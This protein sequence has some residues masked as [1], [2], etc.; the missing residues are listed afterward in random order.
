[1]WNPTTSYSAMR[2]SGWLDDNF[3]EIMDSLTYKDDDHDSN[4]LFVPSGNLTVCYW[5]WPFIVDLPIDGM[6]MFHSSVSLPEGIIM[7]W[8]GFIWWS[9]WLNWEVNTCSTR[10]IFSHIPRRWSLQKM[11]ADVGRV[12]VAWC[13]TREIWAFSRSSTPTR[14]FC[15]PPQVWHDLVVDL[16]LWKIMDWVSNSWAYDIPKNMESQSKFH[17]SKPP[18]SDGFRELRWWFWRTGDN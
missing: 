16:P 8:Y 10:V 15:S 2:T 3:W 14:A 17:G 4:S 12:G 6:V 5:K 7:I 13:C 9:W 11:W 18:T 1:M